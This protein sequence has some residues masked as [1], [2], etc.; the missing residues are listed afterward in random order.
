MQSGN[1]NK[2]ISRKLCNREYYIVKLAKT[3]MI[4]AKS[5]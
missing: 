4:L 2:V 5:R 1:L 3:I